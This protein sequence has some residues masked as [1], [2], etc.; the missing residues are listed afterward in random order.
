M[1]LWKL[2]A[3]CAGA[4][5][6]HFDCQTQSMRYQG[7]SISTTIGKVGKMAGRPSVL[8]PERGV[9]TADWEPILVRSCAMW[10]QYAVWGS[11]RLSRSII[12]HIGRSF[13][14]ED[15]RG[16]RRRAASFNAPF[17]RI[18]LSRDDTKKPYSFSDLTRLTRGP[19]PCHRRVLNRGDELH[20]PGAGWALRKRRN[21]PYKRNLHTG[22]VMLVTA[23]TM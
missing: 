20:P 10:E 18:A 15:S 6:M 12:P 9:G 4:P 21:G 7:V 23:L 8:G 19:C 22:I 13:P 5:G 16:S 17:S 3:A 1:G 14:M 2:L 11:L